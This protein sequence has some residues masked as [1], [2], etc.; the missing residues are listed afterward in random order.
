M[1]V[2]AGEP[3]RILAFIEAA[4]VTG[5]AKNL[6]EFCR[7]VHGRGEVEVSIATFV[8]GTEPSAFTDAVRAAG[9]PLHLITE[10]SAFDRQVLGRIRTL[11]AEQQPDIVQTHAVKSHFLVYLSGVWKSRR[12]VAFHHGYTMTDVKM[13]VYNQLDRVSLRAP[14]RLVT[15]SQ[16]FAQQLRS[17]GVAA[18][19]IRVVQ[20]AV[21][22]GW[23]ERVRSADRTAIRRQLGIAPDE[24]VI[25]SIGRMSQEK[26][27]IDLV[28]AFHRLRADARRARLI[29][30]GDGPERP[31]LGQEAGDGII[32]T[33]QV[34]D[35]T[36]YYAAADLMVLPSL[37]EGSP[38][39]LLEAMAVNVPVVATEVGGIPE[40]VRHDES[41]VLVRPRDPAALAAAIERVLAD[42]SLQASLKRNARAAI[43]ARHT[44]EGRARI[45]VDMY[46][47]VLAGES[48]TRRAR[49][50]DVV[51]G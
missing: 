13:R 34:R 4:T 18:S 15:V 48:G 25:V 45:L 39:A 43:D 36:M 32:F 9:I 50:T 28:R 42:A 7:T 16:S 30:V 23:A 1:R 19:K 31:H 27:H 29:L 2:G 47:D 14:H 10:R 11:V 12:W 20:N 51:L 35:T 22:P 44:P 5:P 8:R 37:T 33:G 38:N 21:D 6:I 26:A 41:A 46:N 49:R 17:Q 3:V 24:D 40:I